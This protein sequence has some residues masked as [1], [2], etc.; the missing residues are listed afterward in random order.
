[1]HGGGSCVDGLS[2]SEIFG[3]PDDLKLRSSMTLFES[4]ADRT[5]FTS[6]LEKYF[7]GERDVG[8]LDLL[9]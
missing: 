3:T 4:I 6:V 1:M 9:S 7:D 5:V 8:T 2:V